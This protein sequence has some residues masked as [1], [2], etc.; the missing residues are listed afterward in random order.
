MNFF[1][2]IIFRQEYNNS[3]SA[4]LHPADLANT[5]LLEQTTH[6]RGLKISNLMRY[7]N[8]KKKTIASRFLLFRG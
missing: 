4:G 6:K 8:P 3:S 5:H 1:D 2:T 7:S